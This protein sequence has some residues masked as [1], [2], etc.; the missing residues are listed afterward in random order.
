MVTIPNRLQAHIIATFTRQTGR[1]S[2]V[3]SLSKFRKCVQVKLYVRSHHWSNGIVCVFICE[4][5][6]Y[7]KNRRLAISSGIEYILIVLFTS[8]LRKCVQYSQQ[9]LHKAHILM[10]S[11][12]ALKCRKL[13]KVA[14]RWLLL[15]LTLDWQVLKAAVNIWRNN[16]KIA[17]D[18]ILFKSSFFLDITLSPIA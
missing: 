4:I 8:P 3:K 2:V 17:M 5:T 14:I 13:T 1:Q 16:G 15:S 18:Y 11:R 9:L 7:Y 10:N 12:V 6:H